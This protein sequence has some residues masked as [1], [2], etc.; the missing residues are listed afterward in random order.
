MIHTIL[1]MLATF[2]VHPLFYVGIL[3]LAMIGA[4]RVAKERA[5]FHTRVYGKRAEFILTV[6]PSLLAGFAISILTISFGITMSLPLLLGLAIVPILF[7]CGRALQLQTPAY[8]MSLVLCCFVVLSFFSVPNMFTT[9]LKEAAWLPSL[10][11]LQAL[12]LFAQ[13]MLIRHNGATLSSPQLSYS[14]R[15]RL[16]GTHQMKRLWLLPVVVF[17]PEGL[18]PGFAMTFGDV[19]V[20]PILVPF[21]LGFQKNTHAFLPTVAARR[22]AVPY[23][24]SACLSLLMAM[25]LYMY[26]SPWLALI[27]ALSIGIIHAS[28]SYYVYRKE[29][30]QPPLFTEEE[31][32]VRIVGILP[33]SPAA[34]MGLAIGEEIVNVNGCVVFDERTL[35]GALQKNPVFCKLKIRDRAG[36]LRLVQGALYDG[37]HH[38]MGVL[39]VRRDEKRIDSVI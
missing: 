12:L 6:L 10:F 19:S 7:F 4:T 5:S 39:L 34:K 17:I 29:Q 2:F 33:G 13:S 30:Q 38:Q 3:C 28:S 31:K 15:G 35:Y 26:A 8:T 1:S 24:I 16:I 25:G 27:G 14:K 20:Q 9:Q 37:E 11:L 22:E 18:L 36:E 32:S 21:L 23:F